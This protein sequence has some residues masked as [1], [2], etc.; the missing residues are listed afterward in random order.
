[1]KCYKKSN[2]RKFP[3][4]KKKQHA[5]GQSYMHLIKMV[6]RQMIGSFYLMFFAFLF[7]LL[8]LLLLL[9]LSL[10]SLLLLLTEKTI[11]GFKI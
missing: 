6:S 7:V 11:Q 2:A 3:I 1:M 10:L 8:L 9:L 4:Y 5:L